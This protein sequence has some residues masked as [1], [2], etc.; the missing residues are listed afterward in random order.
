MLAA[1][2]LGSNSFHMVIAADSPAGLV[3]MDSLRTRVQLAAGIDSQGQLA[4]DSRSRAIACL[5]EFRQ[6]LG[7]IPSSQVRA[8]GTNTLRQTRDGGAFLAQASEAL[9]YPIDILSG[10]EEGRLIYLGVAHDLTEPASRRLVV[11]IGGGSTECVLGGA[12]EPLEIHSLEV[13][14]VSLSAS[15]F[16][17]GVV[18]SARME[19]AELHARREV[20]TLAHRFRERGWSESVGASGTI[21][22]V[23]GILQAMNCSAYGITERGLRKLRKALVRAGS[24]DRLSL[25]GLSRDRAPVLPG[26]LAILLAVFRELGVGDMKVSQGALREGVLYDL[27]GRVHDEDLRSKS[28]DELAHRYRIDDAQAR[29]VEKAAMSVFGQV[30]APW[31][32]EGGRPLLSWASRIHELGLAVTYKGHHRH[33]AYLIRYSNLPGFSA[34][35]QDILAN[36]VLGHRRKLSPKTLE[37]VPPWSGVALRRL[38][39]LVRLAVVLCRSREDAPQIVAAAKGDRLRLGFPPGWLDDH[40]LTKADLYDEVEHLARVGI[41][42]VVE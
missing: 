2:D 18:D 32:L 37:S 36:L 12:N 20:A 21:K 17:D 25:A 19:R 4:D 35:E 27:R 3:V 6:R 23:E 9:G 7:G 11:D 10:Y 16:G 33:G 26:G 41:E 28:I 1:V 14:C 42:L 8:V 39:A 30:S 34:Q 38:C 24:I 15:Y 29:R 22:A 13:G 31:N 5:R 40:P